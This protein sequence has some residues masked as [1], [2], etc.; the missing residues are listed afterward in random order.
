M[1]PSTELP[2]E[3]IDAIIDEVAGRG[4]PDVYWGETASDMY[5]CCL[6]S[7]RFV[8]RARKHL[9]RKIILTPES[10]WVGGYPTHF[11]PTAKRFRE[12]VTPFSACLVETVVLSGPTKNLYHG[13]E[14]DLEEWVAK[15]HALAQVIPSLSALNAV[16]IRGLD[17]TSDW[18]YCLQ[19]MFSQSSIETVT[20]S[21]VWVAYRHS[22]H[23]VL[24]AFPVVREIRVIKPPRNVRSCYW[25]NSLFDKSDN[26]SWRHGLADESH[27]AHLK[28]LVLL[29]AL[30]SDVSGLARDSGRMCLSQ[31]NH[32][33]LRPERMT[34]DDSEHGPTNEVSRLLASMQSLE[35]LSLDL[36]LVTEDSVNP[37]WL[38]SSLPLQNLRTFTITCRMPAL[39]LPPF[40]ETSIFVLRHW[41]LYV[42]SLAIADQKYRLELLQVRIII[43]ADSD[44]VTFQSTFEWDALPVSLLAMD[45]LRRVDLVIMAGDSEQEVVIKAREVYGLF[46][47]KL[48]T[49]GNAYHELA[50]RVEV[51]LQFDPSSHL[52]ESELMDGW[53]AECR[54]PP[55]PA[56]LISGEKKTTAN[57]ENK[58]PGNTQASRKS[59]G[60]RCLPVANF[61]ELPFDVLLEIGAHITLYDLLHLCR[62]NNALRN[63]FKTKS[64]RAM[65]KQARAN[66]NDLPDPF[67]EFSE[68][69]WANL[70]YVRVC[71]FCWKTKVMEPDFR[72]RCRICA[73]CSETHLLALKE[74]LDVMP[75]A[76]RPEIDNFHIDSLAP[77]GQK[78]Q[79]TYVR[80]TD[81]E[82]ME[83]EIRLLP[84]GLTDD[85]RKKK[86][87]VRKTL[88][89]HANVCEDWLGDRTSDREAELKAA[90]K[91]RRNA[92]LDRLSSAGHENEVQYMVARPIG[93]HAYSEHKPI[94][95]KFLK[96]PQVRQNRVLTDCVWRNIEAA[97][98]EYMI[99]V[100][101]LRT[102][103]VTR[104]TTG[105]PKELALASMNPILKSL[106]SR[107]AATGVL[108]ASCTHFPIDFSQSAVEEF[109][110]AK[111]LRLKPLFYPEVLTHKCA[112]RGLRFPGSRDNHFL[113]E[114]RSWSW[115]SFFRTPWTPVL[116]LK[117]PVMARLTQEVVTMA[118]LDPSS[119]T[120]DD[121]DGCGVMFEC[122]SRHAMVEHLI[123][124]AN[125]DV[126]IGEISEGWVVAETTYEEIMYEC[127]HCHDTPQE[128]DVGGIED[129]KMMKHLLD[130]HQLQNPEANTYHESVLGSP[131]QETPRCVRMTLKQIADSEADA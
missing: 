106:L 21:S 73:K 98:L 18:A 101:T 126:H 44:V 77:M 71:N 61:A 34:E 2:Q 78:V 67:P 108:C 95:E 4:P 19:A 80:L 52:G 55:W 75:V 74:F 31:I 54:P 16:E 42:R 76:D 39:R 1:P 12:R 27:L 64:S 6:T 10:A 53:A 8:P 48:S 62:V 60:P 103:G 57:K 38:P 79:D 102:I 33:D 29:D 130:K 114:N 83:N 81:Y 107:L 70:I 109:L 99:G 40:N 47:N 124:S 125:F 84:K 5:A 43:V 66:A 122:G 123:G 23:G 88:M 104:Y 82:D 119:A 68:P 59:R 3:I 118:G 22:L 100:R 35:S 45:H 89:K 91:Q 28:S 97:I 112:V 129:E 90:G 105:L 56:Q 26:P 113:D 49:A 94:Y 51:C 20:F 69:A 93:F 32:L 37:E 30:G 63:V 7:Q 72:L 85:F 116:Y 24:G 15:D 127:L 46:S 50:S 17:I 14:T 11:T 58:A 36:D 41:G 96:L 121:M 117:H 9:F 110:S 131:S 25:S 115:V 86:K 13:D 128:E 120:V 65:W 92:I 111:V 87:E